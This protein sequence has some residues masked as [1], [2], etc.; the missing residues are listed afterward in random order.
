MAEKR[1]PTIQITCTAKLQLD[2]T[3]LAKSYGLNVTDFWRPI[4]E[5]YIELNREQIEKYRELRKNQIKKPSTKKNAPF[6]QV[7]EDKAG[8]DNAKN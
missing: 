4:I 7:T 6:A 8:D 1:K 5:E 3:D 2:A